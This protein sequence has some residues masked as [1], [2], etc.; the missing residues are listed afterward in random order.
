MTTIAWV[1]LA[2]DDIRDSKMSVACIQLD[3]KK[4]FYVNR[5]DCFSLNT[6]FCPYCGKEV[7]KR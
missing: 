2:D 1:D 3:C 4:V 7:R 5:D 6:L